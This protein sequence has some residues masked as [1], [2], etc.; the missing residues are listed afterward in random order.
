[1]IRLLLLCGVVLAS[2]VVGSAQVVQLPS[3]RQFSTTGSVLVPDGGT[4]LLG[5]NSTSSSGSRRQGLNR[6][7][8]SSA[9][10]AQA[11]ASVT[12][13]DLQ[14]MDEQILGGTPQEFL[15]RSMRQ[16]AAA[17]QV[18]RTAP[19]KS[20]P[21]ARPVVS[22]VVDPNREGKSLV[23]YARRCLSENRRSSAFDAYRMAISK[24]DRKLANLAFT[25]FHKVF[26]AAAISAVRSDG[27]VN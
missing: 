13:I 4:T 20:E 24:L 12:I 23:R 21:L 15:R 3:F 6:S 9:G 1:M 2:S 10:V 17:R 22:P 27:L 16:E 11:T 14:A 25:E 7:F 19:V 5:G 8:G 18:A 26:G